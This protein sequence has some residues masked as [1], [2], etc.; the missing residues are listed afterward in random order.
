[1]VSFYYYKQKMSKII[2]IF[3]F[4]LIGCTDTFNDPI[5]FKALNV[6]LSDYDEILINRE[7]GFHRVK[8]V[9]ES[10]S[11]FGIIAVHGY[12]P[13]GWSSKGFEWMEPLSVLARKGVPLWFY[14]YDWRA[15]PDDLVDT[16]QNQI[17]ELIADKEHLD[18]LWIMGHSFG[19]LIVSLFSE[20]WD[21]E[22]PI[23]AHSVAAPLN[24]T[25]REI[26]K[27][28]PL[29]R[30]DYDIVKNINY[31]QWRTLHLQDGAFKKL[32]YDPQDITINNGKTILLPKEWDGGRLG[33]NRSILFVSGLIID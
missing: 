18:S 4:L 11:S 30:A 1:M 16:L 3:I 26:E 14:R 28:K 33:H 9:N 12:Y 6:K 32:E 5:T 31:F 25:T 2:Y 13:N 19:G 8:G 29:N 21:E 15:C 24:S 27:C 17:K 10:D 22:F 7:M 20:N 23:T